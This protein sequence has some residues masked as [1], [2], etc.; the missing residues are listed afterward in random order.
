MTA[1][2]PETSAIGHAKQVR[3]TRRRSPASLALRV[4]A[5][6]GAAITLVFLCFQWA[7]VRS[8]EHH[9]A[10]QDAHELDAVISAL[11]EPLRQGDDMDR[12]ALGQQ[13]ANAVAG[14]HGMSYAVYDQTGN[15]IY[16]TA[17]PDL[18]KMNLAPKPLAQIDAEEL[19]VW[20]DRQ[21]SYRG[22]AFEFAAGPTSDAP[23]YRILAA[24]DIGFHLEFLGEFQRMLRWVTFMVLCIALLAA[25]L[26]VHWGHL[27]IRKVNEKIRA[28]RS[29]KLDVRL[30]P[31][32]VPIELSELVFAF[33]D[34]LARIEEGFAR[35][36]HFSADIAHELRT[37]VTNLVTQT[38]VVLGQPRSAEEYRE[39]LYSHLEEFDR[40][41]RMI[42]D[43][44][45]LAQT[46]NDP[47]NIRMS[48]VD[49]S[50]LVR[51]LF[52][53]Y[54]AL[55]DDRH[56]TLSLKGAVEPVLADREMLSRAIGNLLSN[57]I[58]YTPREA[59]IIVTLKQ[60]DQGTVIRVENPGER[61]S[62]AD[63]PKLFDRFYRADPAR[64]RKSAGAGL[65]LAIVKSIAEAH[66]GH[67]QATSNDT[68]IKFD[69][70]LPRIA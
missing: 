14:H 54:E 7:I 42:A 59:R 23:R 11:A 22:V 30:D 48:Q 38:H 49:L 51:G 33:N 12:D 62:D 68:A 5:L 31:R 61:I 4:T 47:R 13:L 21:R 64:Q 66:G 3:P 28:I 1:S 29:S 60:D 2:K 43:M 25:W 24:M 16:A 18:S 69:L 56:I 6:I 63:L 19:A 67:V 41:S 10:Q 39:I 37:P 50:A 46:E 8:L 40:M 20:Q 27:P 36:S 52:D 15:T 70:T 9:F 17:G 55:A 58:R 35:L 57:A 45:F 53:Y 44:L 26:A 34:M 32:D 65:G